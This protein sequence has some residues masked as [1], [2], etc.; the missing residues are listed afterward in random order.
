MWY[1]LILIL[2]CILNY[3]HKESLLLTLIVGL[4]ILV[5]IPKEYGALAWYCLCV[6]VEFIVLLFALM[7]NS[8]AAKPIASISVLFIL[9]HFLGY[10]FDGYPIQSPYHYFAR[11]LEYTE[12][13]LCAVL[14]HPIINYVKER[15]K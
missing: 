15:I 2:A 5:P 4:G 8:K 1:V 9:V 11:T 6:S 14:S 13:F 10:T 12:L 7:S 3:Q